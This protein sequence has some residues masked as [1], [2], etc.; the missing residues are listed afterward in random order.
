MDLDS[1]SPLEH[2]YHYVYI[3]YMTPGKQ[4]YHH[5]NAETG[6]NGRLSNNTQCLLPKLPLRRKFSRLD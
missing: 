4:K 2:S 5:L 6:V 1:T 3:K